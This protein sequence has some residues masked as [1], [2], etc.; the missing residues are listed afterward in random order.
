MEQSRAFTRGFQPELWLRISQRLQLKQP[1]HFPDD[2]YSLEEI[3]EAARYVLHGTTSLS[4]PAT[5]STTLTDTLTTATLLIKSEDLASILEHITQSFVKAI[6]S[7][8][9]QLNDNQAPRPP[10]TTRPGCN[11]CGGLDHFMRECLEVLEYIWAGKVK[12]NFEG[13]LTLPSGAFLP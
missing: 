1:D 12:Q 10:A 8:S 6:Q 3:H 7:S 4:T 5:N 11:F 9:G 2:P 13:K